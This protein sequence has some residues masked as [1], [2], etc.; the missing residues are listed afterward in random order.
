MDYTRWMGCSVSHVAS[1]KD[2]ADL[3]WFVWRPMS[4]QAA[5][6]NAC[7]V[8][9]EEKCVLTHGHMRTLVRACISD[10]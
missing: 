1:S 8:E 6:P 4:Q 5:E 2:L 7:N 10:Y 3:P 9:E